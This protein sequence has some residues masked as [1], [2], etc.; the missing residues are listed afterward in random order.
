MTSLLQ[1]INL[2]K[3][4]IVLISLIFLLVFSTP[5]GYIFL[6]GDKTNKTDG[7]E[8]TYVLSDTFLVAIFLSFSILWVTH[9]LLKK[10]ALKNICK[11]ILLLVMAFT[12]FV[13]FSNNM[14]LAQDYIPGIG[15]RL[16]LTLPPLIL[17]YL[18]V[19][20]RLN[21]AK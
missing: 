10:S 3:A 15:V 11:Y 6:E 16:S 20:S 2:K 1:Y 8:P 17:I 12:F 14:L 13:S 21:I 7:W 18:Y 9:I 19:D 5:F 4:L